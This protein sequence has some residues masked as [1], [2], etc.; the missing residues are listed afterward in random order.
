[1]SICFS[2][3]GV[4]YV[5]RQPQCIYMLSA[6]ANHSTTDSFEF[7]ISPKETGYTLQNFRH[8]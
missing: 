4:S 6:T 3:V 2:H 8:F 1:M 7:Y 5:A